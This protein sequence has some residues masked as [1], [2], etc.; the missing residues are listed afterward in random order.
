MIDSN[1][2]GGTINEQQFCECCR[3]WGG[4]T[5][6]RKKIP[7][8]HLKMAQR[9]DGGNR[10]ADRTGRDGSFPSQ[11]VTQQYSSGAQKKI[12]RIS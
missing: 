1:R 2:K 9:H 4:E 3:R 7:E 10:A 11:N 8:R 5:S 6:Y 12:N